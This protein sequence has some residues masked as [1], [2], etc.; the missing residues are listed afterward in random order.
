MR[1]VREDWTSQ[2]LP[3]MLI[4]ETI[5]EFLISPLIFSLGYLWILFDKDRQAW[6][7]KLVS[8]YV[9]RDPST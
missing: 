3:I 2:G 1:V 8:T 7:D 4:R 5:E 6:H 9:I